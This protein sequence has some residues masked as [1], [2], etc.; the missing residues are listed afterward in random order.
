MNKS[1]I[2][3]VQ[4]IEPFKSYCIGH[5][6]VELLSGITNHVLEMFYYKYCS[7]ITTVNDFYGSGSFL[8]EAIFGGPADTS[9]TYLKLP[10]VVPYVAKAFMGN[11]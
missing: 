5:Q 4:V 7:H 10:Y 6:S 8:S 1:K 11:N 2:E 9:L 3:R